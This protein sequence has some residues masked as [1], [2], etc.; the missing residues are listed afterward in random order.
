MEGYV[1]LAQQDGGLAVKAQNTVQLPDDG[2]I[3]LALRDPG[4]RN[5]AAVL[6]AVAGV[7]DEGGAAGQG[8]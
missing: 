5:C 6:P 1:L 3:D 2:Q 7:Q 4:D 8:M